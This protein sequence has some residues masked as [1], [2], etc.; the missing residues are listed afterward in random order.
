[1][2][3]QDDSGGAVP[4]DPAALLGDAAWS[5]EEERLWHTERLRLEAHDQH[6]LQYRLQPLTRPP[7]L[8]ATES[9]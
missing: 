4:T 1:M 8:H 2:C 7:S 6:L 3:L 5:Q 9:T